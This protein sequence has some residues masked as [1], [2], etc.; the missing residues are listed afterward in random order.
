MKVEYRIP[1]GVPDYTVLADD[2]LVD[3]TEDRISEY[4]PSLRAA[5]EVD[6]LPVPPGAPFASFICGRAGQINIAFAVARQHGSADGA[7]A[8]I[9]A[10]L[11]A[12][13]VAGQFHLKITVGASKSYLAFAAVTEVRPDQHSDQSTLIRYAFTGSTYTTEEP[14]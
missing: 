4:L 9:T 13:A 6:A 7:L 1:G 2:S 10:Q 11:L 3:G 12:F 14:A 8:F 5:P